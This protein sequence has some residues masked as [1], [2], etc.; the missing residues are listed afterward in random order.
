MELG[1]KAHAKAIYSKKRLPLFIEST[2]LVTTLFEL[3]RKLPFDRIQG[4]DLKGSGGERG[5]HEVFG[6]ELA[7]ELSF[8]GE[9]PFWAVARSEWFPWRCG[10]RH[11]GREELDGSLDLFGEENVGDARDR[12][13]CR[14]LPGGEKD[15]ASHR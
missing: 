2:D 1:P 15:K 12:G 10:R 5:Q 3:S 14:T 9:D 7:G 11:Q 6:R 4:L 13:F 8:K